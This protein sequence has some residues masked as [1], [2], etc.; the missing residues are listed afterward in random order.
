MA[1]KPK[2]TIQERAADP[3]CPECGTEV[4]RKSAKGPAPKFCGPDCRRA[5]SNR[6]MV[7]GRAVIAFLKAWRAD[8]GS[9]EIAKTAFAQACQILDGF[10]SN[11]REQGRPRPDLYAAKMM[12]DG[13]LYMDRARQ[14]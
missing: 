13:T 5:H 6:H 11:D 2:P 10:N 8:R 1:S 9:G 14:R 4:A 12:A 3:I 7:E